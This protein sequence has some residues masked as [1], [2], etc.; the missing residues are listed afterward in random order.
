MKERLLAL[1]PYLLRFVGY[2]AFFLFWFVTFVYFTFPYERLKETI[3]SSVEAPRRVAGGLMQPSNMQMSIG[4]LGPTILPGVRARNVSVTFL[5]TKTGERPVTMR[6]NAVT[7]HVGLFSL[8]AGHLNTDIDVDGMGGTVEAHVDQTFRGTRPGL[9]DLKVTLDNVRVGEL[10]P[11]V[12]LVGLPLSGSMDGNIELHVPEGRFDQ[13]SGSMRV[14]IDDLRI[15]DGHAQY[16]IPRFGGVT[17]EQIRAGRLDGA[18]TI[19]DGVATIDR[20]TSRSNEFNFAMDGRVQ[21]QPVLGDSTMNA[22]VRFQLTDAYRHKSEAAGRI[23]S[24]MD[25][26][27]DLQQARRPDGMLAFRCRGNFSRGLTCPPDRG[28]PG[29]AGT[30]PRR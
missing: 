17:I 5:P 25:I 15:G 6:M 14:S 16:Q 13:A 12:Q 26:V 2:P 27:P 8:L 19:R 7:A 10:A 30:V 20:L 28:G 1:R 22:S 9:R 3:I 24:V 18:I 29:G 21:L 4:E 11:V 23:M